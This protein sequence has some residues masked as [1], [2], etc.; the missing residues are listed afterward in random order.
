MADAL[1]QGCDSI[2]TIVRFSPFTAFSV[3]RDQYASSLLPLVEQYL[4]R[5][6]NRVAT[7]LEM[8]IDFL[9]AS[10]RGA[11]NRTTVEQQQHVPGA[12]QKERPPQGAPCL[13]PVVLACSECIQPQMRAVTGTSVASNERHSLQVH[14]SGLPPRAAKH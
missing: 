6:Q 11:Y 13:L 5:V 10:C 12:L 7:T 4:L 3:V 2:I 8:F 9:H 1:R 14:G